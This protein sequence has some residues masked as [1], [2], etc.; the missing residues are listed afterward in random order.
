MFYDCELLEQVH[1]P[2]SVREIGY[3]AFADCAHLSA[4]NIPESVSIIGDSAFDNCPCEKSLVFPDG[5]DYKSDPYR[6]LSEAQE[7]QYRI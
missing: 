2:D 3:A 1:L 6:W 7:H 5:I 4:I